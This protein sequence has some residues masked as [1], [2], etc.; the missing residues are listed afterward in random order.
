MSK[1]PYEWYTGE[2]HPLFPLIFM[3][4]IEMDIIFNPIVYTEIMNTLPRYSIRIERGE[5]YI[6]TSPGIYH[7]LYDEIH[8]HNRPYIVEHLKKCPQVM[9]QYIYYCVLQEKERRRRAA[10]I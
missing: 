7:S 9:I 1:N 6:Q 8:L 3:S 10:A 2:N 4:K 5:L